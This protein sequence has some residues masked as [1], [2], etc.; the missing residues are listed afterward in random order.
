MCHI[1]HVKHDM[2]HLSSGGEIPFCR[3][4]VKDPPVNNFPQKIENFKTAIFWLL[5]VRGSL[6]HHKNLFGPIFDQ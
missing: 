6:I 4:K 2:A 3:R 1:C 5:S